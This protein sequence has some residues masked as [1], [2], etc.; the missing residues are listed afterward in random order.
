M[1]KIFKW[2]LCAACVMG[3]VACNN[4]QKTDVKS[5]KEE[6]L[7]RAMAP[8]VNNTVIAT[9]SHMADEGINLRKH[10]D[11]ILTSVEKEQDYTEAMQKAGEAWRAMRKYWEQ[12]DGNNQRRSSMVPLLHTT[13][14][15]ILIHG[16]SIS[17]P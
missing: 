5:D 4:N 2:A 3:M 1:K 8:Y 11:D 17:T 13:S 6:A 12:S 9:Y 10:C 16:R 15:R 7:E 14:I